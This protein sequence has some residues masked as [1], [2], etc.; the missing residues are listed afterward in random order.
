MLPCAQGCRLRSLRLQR[1]FTV[2]LP[3][4]LFFII[5]KL[6][7][8]EGKKKVVT[9][10]S[11]HQLAPFCVR[12]LF[13]SRD[14]PTRTCAFTQKYTHSVAFHCLP[15]L[16]LASGLAAPLLSPLLLKAKELVQS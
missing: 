11:N 4:L 16:K 1:A 9:P 6:D 2:P 15:K 3:G 10:E 14:T 12:K 5:S 7:L 8:Q 13:Y